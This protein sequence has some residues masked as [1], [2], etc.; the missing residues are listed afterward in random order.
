MLYYI[1]GFVRERQFFHRWGGEGMVQAV[2]QAMG[3][4]MVQ[5]VVRVMGNDEE[6]QM[7]LHP[8]AC[9]LPPAVGRGWGPLLY[10]MPGDDSTPY[11]YG[12]CIP[13]SNDKQAGN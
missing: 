10:T 2:M 7:K 4:G 6:Q 11:Y 8:F 3:W 1:T 5:V 12:I 13:C 9:R